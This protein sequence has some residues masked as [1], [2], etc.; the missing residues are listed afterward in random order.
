MLYSYEQRGV[1][2]IDHH[3]ATQDFM[4]F[5]GQEVGAGRKI[6]GRWSW[7]VPPIS[8]SATPT[9]HHEWEEH[10]ILP[11]YFYQQHAWE[12]PARRG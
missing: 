11:Q 5:V 6:A 2:L 9:F 8:G 12:H 10:T 7:L 3:A 4:E 1:K